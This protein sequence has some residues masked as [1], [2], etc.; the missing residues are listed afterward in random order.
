MN[1]SDYKMPLTIQQST[2]FQNNMTIQPTASHKQEIKMCTE[3]TVISNVNLH[4]TKKCQPAAGHKQD[5]IK[6][7]FVADSWL[8]RQNKK[9]TKMKNNKSK[10]LSNEINSN[11]HKTKKCQPA[12]GHRPDLI[13]TESVA[14]SWLARQNKKS[15][16]M[17]NNKL[18]LQSNEVNSTHIKQKSVSL[19]PAT[20]R[21]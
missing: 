17:E 7:E 21:I 18:K 1:T 9:S 5:L 4:K 10:L 20:D 19:L 6:T 12:A 15:L 3:K 16:K 8:A 11:L 13:K 14:D 2:R